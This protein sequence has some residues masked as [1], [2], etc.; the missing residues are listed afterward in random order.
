MVGNLRGHY[1]GFINLLRNASSWERARSEYANINVPTYIVWGA[2]DWSLPEERRYDES[3]IPGV[4]SV[5]VEAGGHFL[6]LDAP[7]D[8]VRHIRSAA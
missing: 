7:D 2:E 4:Q 5:T 1:R 3:L 8:V 6:P